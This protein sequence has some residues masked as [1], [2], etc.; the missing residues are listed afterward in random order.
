[1]VTPRLIQSQPLTPRDRSQGVTAKFDNLQD[2]MCHLKGV[3]VLETA[4]SLDPHVQVAS[5]GPL[6]GTPTGAV[7]GRVSAQVLAD[8]GYDTAINNTGAKGV[9]WAISGPAGAVSFSDDARGVSAT[10]VDGNGARHAAVSPGKN[11]IL[12]MEF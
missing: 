11:G 12:Y 6:D 1:M 4:L 7:L 5:F 3:D 9:E 2:A 8:Q 10:V